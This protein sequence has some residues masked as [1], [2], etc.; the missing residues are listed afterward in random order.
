[1]SRRDLPE[2]RQRRGTPEPMPGRCGHKLVL[3]DP[4]RYCAKWPRKKRNGCKFHGGNNKV[5]IESPNFKNGSA[6]KHLD[7][8]LP[9]RVRT[10]YEQLLHDPQLLSLERE[11]ALQR[12]QYQDI[13][14]QA[15]DGTLVAKPLLAAI[16]A[17]VASWRDLTAA[18]TRQRRLASAEAAAKAMAALKDAMDPAAV[19]VAARDELRRTWVVAERLV[20]SENDRVEKLYN[21]ITAERAFALRTAEVRI[22]LEGL[23]KH[24]ADPAERA[25]VRRFV[26]ARFSELAGRRERPALDAAGGSGDPAAAA[27]QPAASD[28]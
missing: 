10:E 9:Q 17:V 26:A 22:F 11:I 16:D 23:E 1:M 19:A 20:R 5:G 28:D 8:W 21:M 12:Q 4:P 27:V 15:T 3:T 25:A 18:K 6:S 14:R 2:I 7:E 24:V 13:Y